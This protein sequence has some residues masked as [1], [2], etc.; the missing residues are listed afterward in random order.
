[1][2]I[3]V[4]LLILIKKVFKLYNGSIINKKENK[5]NVFEFDQINIDLSDYSSNTILV[6]KVQES[7]S[8]KLINCSLISLQDNKNE[9]NCDP[10]LIKEVNQELLKD[11]INQFI[12]L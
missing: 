9:M 10:S 6:P 7:S 3:V 4:K 5:I 8:Y 12:F 1:M 2:Q 11:F